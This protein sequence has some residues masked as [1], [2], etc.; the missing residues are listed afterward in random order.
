MLLKLQRRNTDPSLLLVKAS[1]KDIDAAVDC[2][3]YDRL[4]S[5]ITKSQDLLDKDEMQPVKKTQEDCYEGEIHT[6]Y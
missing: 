3:I 1:G 6:K 2:V 5:Q 4:I